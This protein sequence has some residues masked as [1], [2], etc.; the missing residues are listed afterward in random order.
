MLL[1]VD[2]T[3]KNLQCARNIFLLHHE[4]PFLLV[5]VAGVKDPVAEFLTSVADEQRT[6]VASSS[7]FRTAVMARASI[8][9]APVPAS[10]DATWIP[11]RVSAGHHVIVPLQKRPVDSKPFADRISVGRAPNNDVVIRHDSVSK[12]HAWFE[13]ND[14]EC[15]YVADANSTNQS[16]LNGEEL[17]KTLT[18]VSDGDV[19]QFGDVS[20]MFV[21]PESLWDAA[22]AGGG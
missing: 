21:T 9:R 12:F 20:T 15:F 6:H 19:I 7:R 10:R 5:E 4:I 18:L 1:P 11:R 22:S 16:L 13:K 3:A 8:T 2:W 17:G 14:S